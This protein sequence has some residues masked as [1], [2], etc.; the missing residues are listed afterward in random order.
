[1]VRHFR[2]VSKEHE[3][4]DIGMQNDAGDNF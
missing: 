1:M 2:R 3:G 4:P